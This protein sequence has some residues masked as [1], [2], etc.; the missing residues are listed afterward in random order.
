M[1]IGGDL[2]DESE[3]RSL[4]LTHYSFCNSRILL[5]SLPLALHSLL[6][7]IMLNTIR[8]I[9]SGKK[10][11][12]KEEGFDLDLVRITVRFPLTL[13]FS[14]TFRITHLAILPRKI[15]PNDYNGLPSYRS[16]FII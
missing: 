13:T 4:I 10:Q 5:L 1:F 15:G 7:T 12:Y 3:Q 16:S 9:V 11:R 2:E 14:P 6:T 8:G